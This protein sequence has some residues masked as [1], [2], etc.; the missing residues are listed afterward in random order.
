[1][2]ILETERLTLRVFQPED[3]DGFAPIE[4]DP[5]VMRFY[6]SGPRPREWAERSVRYFMETQAERG[7]SPWA[8]IRKSDGRFL[9]FCGLIPQT[10]E[11]KEEVEV[12]YKLAHDV[13][14]QGLATEAARAVRE[15]AFANLPVPR[16]VAIIDPG[17]TTSLRVAEKNGMAYE[18]DI[19]Y[20][21][22]PC[23]LYAIAR[24]VG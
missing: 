24:P 21:G 2:T 16:L 18:R 10:I 9:G 12:G 14:G 5:D 13:W 7:Y 19:T 1:V 11:F 22:K 3:I 4:A 17:N 8:V 6:A 20:D 15:W 23:R